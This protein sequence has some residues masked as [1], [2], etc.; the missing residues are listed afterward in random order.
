MFET[1]NKLNKLLLKGLYPNIDK[2]EGLNLTKV[3]ERN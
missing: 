1:L 2:V 3:L